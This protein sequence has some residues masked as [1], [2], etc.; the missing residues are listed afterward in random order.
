MT[1]HNIYLAV[2]WGGSYGLYNRHTKFLKPGTIYTFAL[3]QSKSLPNYDDPEELKLITLENKISEEEIIA[4]ENYLSV[5]VLNV[6]DWG[7]I[8][9]IASGGGNIPDLTYSKNVIFD[10]FDKIVLEGIFL[11]RGC[12]ILEKE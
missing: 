5:I 4:G 11:E 8:Q 9:V 7:I 2:G 10:M 1:R 12:L 6:I 3:N